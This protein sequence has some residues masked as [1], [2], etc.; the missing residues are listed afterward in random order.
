MTLLTFYLLL[1]GAG[2]IGLA[3]MEM[4]RWLKR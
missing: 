1:N 4:E 3:A 2:L